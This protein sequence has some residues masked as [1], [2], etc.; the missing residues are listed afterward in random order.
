MENE[1]I[2]SEKITSEKRLE[3]HL[4]K[5]YKVLNWG[6]DQG[7]FLSEN[8]N[9]YNEHKGKFLE[10]TYDNL[11]VGGLIFYFN[12]EVDANCIGCAAIDSFHRGKGHYRTILTTFCNLYSRL[13]LFCK[14]D[15]VPL[16]SKFFN[17][18]KHIP[19]M[20]IYLFSNY[21]TTIEDKGPF[22]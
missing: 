2:T 6:E 4:N 5:Y 9:L 18:Q 15:L 3:N 21:E 16:Y 8:F 22:F 17:Y 20:N 11:V 1:K 13:Y 19:T 7:L 14:P 10:F 12:Q